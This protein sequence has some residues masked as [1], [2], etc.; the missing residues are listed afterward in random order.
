MFPLK[1]VLAVPAVALT[2]LLAW[3]GE[4]DAM[5]HERAVQDD[6]NSGPMLGFDEYYQGIFFAVLEG[7]YRDGVPNEV[8]DALLVKND[9]GA[10]ALFVYACP[11]CMPVLNAFL[12]YRGRGRIQGLKIEV[13]TFGPG[14]PE[15]VTAACTGEDL[16][17]RFSALEGLMQGWVD[18]YV[19]SRRFTEEEK[20][21]W[22]HEMEVRR[23]AGMGYLLPQTV[24]GLDFSQRTCALCEGA[25]FED[26][27]K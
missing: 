23:K 5:T 4:S 27:W 1:A 18:D 26:V 6:Q 17:A 11:I 3:P 24:G 20:K 14:L 8:V 22:N 19:K 13:D 10:P 12:Q 15:D 16:A 9:E 25:N 2:T 7:L 21:L